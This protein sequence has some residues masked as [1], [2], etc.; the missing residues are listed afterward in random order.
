MDKETETETAQG[1]SRAKA[2]T[3][4]QCACGV[5][6]APAALMVSGADGK[7]RWGGCLKWTH[8][9]KEQHDA[10]RIDQPRELHCH[11]GLHSRAVE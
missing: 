10:A 11:P 2:K 4:S 7:S 8:C 9:S 3:E 1:H 5:A 6:V